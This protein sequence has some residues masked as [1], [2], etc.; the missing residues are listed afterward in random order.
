LNKKYAEKQILCSVKLLDKLDLDQ[1]KKAG[2][3]FKRA[4]G[5]QN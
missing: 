5:L 2:K 1:K 3:I 4:R